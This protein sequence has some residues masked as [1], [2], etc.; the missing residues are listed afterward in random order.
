MKSENEIQRE[1]MQYL[2]L[3]NIPTTRNH[4]GRVRVGRHWLNLGA[5]GWPD[6]ICCLPPYGFFLGIEIKKPGEE[7]SG[8]QDKIRMEIE[9]ANGKVIIVTSVEELA[10]ELNRPYSQGKKRS[11]R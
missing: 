1:I 3:R 7:T 2:K 10:K 8:R 6:I 4:A 11:E 9:Q 5:S